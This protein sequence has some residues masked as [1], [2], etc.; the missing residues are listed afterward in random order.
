MSA[1]RTEN[2][3]VPWEEAYGYVQAVKR[4]DTIYVSGQLAHNGPELVAPAPL[5]ENGKVIDYG[6]M[7]EQMRRS[8]TNA[9]A[10]LRRFGAS[11]ADVVEEVLYVLDIDAAFDVA[12]PIRKAAYGRDDPQVASTLVGTPRLAFPAQLVEIKLTARM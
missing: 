8:Y 10:L 9:E 6:N 2:F 1:T 4:G 11:L 3:G 12:G 5:D 7:G